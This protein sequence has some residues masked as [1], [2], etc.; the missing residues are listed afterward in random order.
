M[1]LSVLRISDIKITLNNSPENVENIHLG[2]LQNNFFGENNFILLDGNKKLFGYLITTYF[3]GNEIYMIN[4]AIQNLNSIWNYKLNMHENYLS[5]DVVIQ[6]KMDMLNKMITDKTLC[7]MDKALLGKLMLLSMEKY[8][9]DFLKL[10]KKVKNS[11]KNGKLDMIPPMKTDLYNYQLDNISWFLNLETNIFDVDLNYNLEQLIKMDTKHKINILTSDIN[12]KRIKLRTKGGYLCDEIGL[13]KTHSIMGLIL[14]SGK[15]DEKKTNLLIVNGNRASHFN[16]LVKENCPYIKYLTVTNRV[17]FNKLTLSNYTNY[18][19]IIVTPQ[20]LL[21]QQFYFT[22][23]GRCGFNWNERIK[24]IN[25][26]KKDFFFETANWSRVICYDCNS[27]FDDYENDV[28]NYFI[29]VLINMNA[30]NKHYVTGTPLNNYVAFKY[31]LQY[32]DIRIQFNDTYMDI[33]QISEH[34]VNMNVIIE[35]I[36]KIIFKRDTKDSVKDIP[37]LPKIKYNNYEIKLTPIE[38]IIHGLC[39]DE[40]KKRQIENYIVLNDSIKNF[41]DQNEVEKINTIIQNKKLLLNDTVG[42]T[43]RNRLKKQIEKLENIEKRNLKNIDCSICLDKIKNMVI[44]SCGHY[45]CKYCLIMSMKKNSSHCPLCRDELDSDKLI[46]FRNKNNFNKLKLHNGS[47]IGKIISINK[48]I[49]YKDSD[50]KVIILTNN[51]K[52]DK[53]LNDKLNINSIKTSILDGN[54]NNRNKVTNNFTNGNINCL[55]I[56]INDVLDV[57]NIKNVSHI[58]FTEEFYK[59][60]DDFLFLQKQIVNKLTKINDNEQVEMVYLKVLN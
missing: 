36:Y 27:F 26:F 4:D 58:I 12:G 18:D 11:R 43:E 29:N 22:N 55:I 32:L 49:L 42:E 31:L 10:R 60:I 45:F 7:Y 35:K 37:Y 54:K 3:N 38:K 30:N 34:G 48:K 16:K 24:I 5:C 6:I 25:K 28:N 46:I 57:N 50:S 21:N 44:T 52:F 51:S 2:W 53:I 9:F 23:K 40:I 20:F 1:S 17:Q 13:G 15:N 59:Y 39:D 47:K 56:N 8:K 41:F 19:L 14:Y 33:Q